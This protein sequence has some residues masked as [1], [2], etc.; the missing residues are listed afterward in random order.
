VAFY[1][2]VK[3]PAD[4]LKGLFCPLLYHRAGAD[5]AVS[6]ADIALLQQAGSDSGR[7]V[8]I[9]S[10]P[11]APSGFC[12]DMRPDVY[13]PELAAEAWETTVSFLA[14]CFKDAR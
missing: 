5:A 3:T 2:P 12:N 11:G 1:G 13:R 10:Y 7:R 14:D 6:D 9:R 8:D 4:V